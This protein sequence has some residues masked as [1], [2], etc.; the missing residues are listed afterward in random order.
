MQIRRLRQQHKTEFA[1]LRQAQRGAYG[2]GT[3]GT[4]RHSQAAHDQRLANYDRHQQQQD[5]RPVQCHLKQIQAHTNGDKKQSEQHVTE[6]LDVVF[7]LV[8]VLGFRNQHAGQECAQ[9]QRQ[10]GAFG[11]IS[12]AQREQQ[13]IQRE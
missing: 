2:E 3:A 6:R 10:A 11:E 4:K 1:R 8:A 7:D 13:Q 5:H 12:Q 9:R